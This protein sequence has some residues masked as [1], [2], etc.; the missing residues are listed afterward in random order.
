MGALYSCLHA[1]IHWRHTGAGIKN[2][3]HLRHGS[4]SRTV[5]APQCIRAK[6]NHYLTRWLWNPNKCPTFFFQYNL[7]RSVKAFLFQAKCTLHQG[8]R[9]MVDETIRK[10]D[11]CLQISSYR[12]AN[13]F[14]LIDRNVL[15]TFERPKSRY[16][17]FADWEESF[18]ILST[19]NWILL[20]IED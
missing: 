4:F 20:W 16:C 8:G 3:I 12:Y 7:S 17:L 6:I 11:R 14:C 5:Q 19:P 9:E 1:F 15:D 10:N 18:K 13:L 2:F